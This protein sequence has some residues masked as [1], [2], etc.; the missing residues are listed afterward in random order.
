MYYVPEKKTVFLANRKTGSRSMLAYLKERY[1][2]QSVG[3]D[4]SF[5]VLPEFRDWFSFVVVRDPYERAASLWW[6]RKGEGTMKM[7]WKEWLRSRAFHQ[8]P[9][10]D[11]PGIRILRFESLSEEVTSLPI[12]AGGD[13][14]HANRSD[15]V[16]VRQGRK[17]PAR[18]ASLLDQ[19][20]RGIIAAQY[21]RD[22]EVFGYKKR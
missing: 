7:E 5:M 12:W 17:W 15:V 6:S 2:V 8:Y 20:A 19:E 4:H 21:A 9:Y 11:N 13:F 22:F 16:A 14:P 1:D 18:P 3:A 10:A